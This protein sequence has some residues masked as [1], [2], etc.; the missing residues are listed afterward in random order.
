MHLKGERWRLADGEEVVVISQAG[1]F[2]RVLLPNGM[3]NTIHKN[4]LKEWVNE[5]DF[6]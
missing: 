2:V 5:K 6:K 4:M 1:G 3:I